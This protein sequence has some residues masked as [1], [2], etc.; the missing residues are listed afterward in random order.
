[1][2]I[3]KNNQEVFDKVQN[4][5]LTGV[6]KAQNLDAGKYPSY[7]HTPT[8][9]FIGMLLEPDLAQRLQD[10]CDKTNM[11]AISNLKIF[12]ENTGLGHNGAVYEVAR[13]FQNCDS[14]F[15][16]RLQNIHDVFEPAAWLHELNYIICVFNLN[17]NFHYESERNVTGSLT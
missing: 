3:Y 7:A 13:I 8:G 14:Y 5:V 16:E 6:I 1:M 12:C 10:Y 4:A 11:Y 2:Y 15:L 17:L 9:C